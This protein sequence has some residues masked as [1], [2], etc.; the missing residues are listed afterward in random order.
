[1]TCHLK[2]SGVHTG[3]NAAVEDSAGRETLFTQKD[4]CH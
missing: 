4:G 1:M 2:R 3:D